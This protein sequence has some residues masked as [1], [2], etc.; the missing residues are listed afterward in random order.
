MRKTQQEQMLSAVEPITDILG[1]AVRLRGD[2]ASASAFHNRSLCERVTIPKAQP[3]DSL[4][5]AIAC[6]TFEM[7]QSCT[8]VSGREDRY[9]TLSRPDQRGHASLN[10]MKLI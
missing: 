8:S 1:F 7:Q 5:A 4:H 10:G 6:S 9:G 2:A 3:L